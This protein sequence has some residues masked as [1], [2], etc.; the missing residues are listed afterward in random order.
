MS[1]EMKFGVA[2]KNPQCSDWIFLG[3]HMTTP[4]PTQ[5]FVG[6]LVVGHWQLTCPSCGEANDYDQNDLREFS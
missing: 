3:T 1:E 6:L 5:D 2:C 4:Q